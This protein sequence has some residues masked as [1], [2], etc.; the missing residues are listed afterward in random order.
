[1]ETKGTTTKVRYYEKKHNNLSFTTGIR[2]LLLFCLG[3]LN[4]LNRQSTCKKINIEHLLILFVHYH[5]L[6]FVQLFF[7]ILSRIIK[8]ER[9]VYQVSLS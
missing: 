6:W 5:N 8:S 4:R 7:T 9:K 3:F 1:M 2:T